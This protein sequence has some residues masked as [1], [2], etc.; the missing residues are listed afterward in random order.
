MVRDVREGDIGSPGQWRDFRAFIPG[1]CM[2]NVAKILSS[3]IWFHL[4]SMCSIY[5]SGFL[6]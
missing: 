4:V 3:C 2:R 6:F 5:L 1:V